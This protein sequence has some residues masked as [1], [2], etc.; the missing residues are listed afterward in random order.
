MMTLLWGTTITR[1]LGPK[2]IFLSEMN[3]KSCETKKRKERSVEVEGNGQSRGILL[4]T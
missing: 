3:V 2:Y 1:V 4:G